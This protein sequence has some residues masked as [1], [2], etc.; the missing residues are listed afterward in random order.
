MK[1]HIG[2]N[3]ESNKLIVGTPLLPFLGEYIRYK[4]AE[5]LEFQ[6]ALAWF[7]VLKSKPVNGA[8]DMAAKQTAQD[9]ER[10]HVPLAKQIVFVEHGRLCLSIVPTVARIRR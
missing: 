2:I 4:L 6:D 3:S 7:L 8:A 9:V 1:R 10:V 5:L